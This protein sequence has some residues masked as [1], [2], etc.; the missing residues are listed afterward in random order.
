MKNENT[1]PKSTDAEQESGKG[2]DET[3][4]SVLWLSLPDEPEVQDRPLIAALVTGD[5]WTDD[6]SQAARLAR[7]GYIVKRRDKRINGGIRETILEPEVLEYA[8]DRGFEMRGE[9]ELN[10]PNA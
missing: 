3:P 5:A 9:R 1:P 7:K 8:V 6:I 10:R 4:C 2:L